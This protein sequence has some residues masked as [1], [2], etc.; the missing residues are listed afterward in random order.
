MAAYAQE[1]APF[2]CDGFPAPGAVLWRTS[3]AD[4][5][6]YFGALVETTLAGVIWIETEGNPLQSA[7]A[8]LVVAPAYQRRGIAR[9]LLSHA[10]SKMLEPG[11]LYAMGTTA[12]SPKS[13][14]ENDLSVKPDF[15]ARLPPALCQPAHLCAK[16]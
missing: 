14:M 4:D 16:M 10:I 15:C 3:A 7:I 5:A 13:I 8:G 1:A 6:L 12:G 9:R 11:I 2:R